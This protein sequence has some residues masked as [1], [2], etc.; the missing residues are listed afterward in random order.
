[1]KLKNNMNI[2]SIFI[3][4]FS[5]IIMIT[6]F[7]T[8]Y[9]II[10]NKIYKTDVKLLDVYSV[11]YAKIIEI[12]KC[13]NL[14][15]MILS[16]IDESLLS[17]L[18]SSDN[19]RMLTLNQS[20]ID[21]A[22]SKK[23]RLFN[24][25]S[26]LCLCFDSKINFR[27]FNSE[28]ISSITITLSN[29]ENLDALSKCESLRKLNINQSTV[30]NN[31]IVVENMKYIMKDSSVFSLLDSVIDLTIIVDEIQDI[32]GILEMDSLETFCV[33][34]DSISE[35]YVKLLEDKGITVTYTEN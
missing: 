31:Y 14:E 35:E 13:N 7:Y 15:S 3:V 1:M 6:Y 16:N 33:N 32:S 2:F 23:I 22:D 11:N 21:N 12:N 24:N 4:V 30:S 27:S 34:R 8:H 19:L 29:S 28:S 10:G 9:A 26:V 18:K 5:I 20:I 25:I 17:K